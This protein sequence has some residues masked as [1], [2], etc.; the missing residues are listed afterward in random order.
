MA[1]IQIW[2][3]NDHVGGGYNYTYI[4]PTQ[5]P[6]GEKI[7]PIFDSDFGLFNI[8]KNIGSNE[9]Q[10]VG[11]VIHSPSGFDAFRFFSTLPPSLGRIILRADKDYPVDAEI[12]FRVPE[13]TGGIIALIL[14]ILI[15]K[16]RRSILTDF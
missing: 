8:F 13:S 16:A 2:S 4:V 1:S 11:P 9:F 7:T 5:S 6:T 14:T 10:Y 15:I 3:Y 12:P